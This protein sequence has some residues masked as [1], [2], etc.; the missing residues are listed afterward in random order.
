VISVPNNLI[1]SG[2]LAEA[3]VGARFFLSVP[4]LLRHR[5]PLADAPGMV[6]RRRE[7]RATA[8]LHIVR[9]GVYENALSPSTR[10]GATRS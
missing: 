8:F 6:R 2:L 10:S 7:G 5:T 3:L 9:R 4:R 1:S